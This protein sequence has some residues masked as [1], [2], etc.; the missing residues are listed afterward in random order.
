MHVGL[1]PTVQNEA[2]APITG[3]YPKRLRIKRHELLLP[4]ECQKLWVKGVRQ[5]DKVTL[6]QRRCTWTVHCHAEARGSVSSTR[7]VD[8]L[9]ALPCALHDCVAYHACVTLTSVAWSPFT[10]L[11]PD[12]SPPCQ[13]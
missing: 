10:L 2:L 3:T 9:G 11:R 7:K 13:A 8:P 6:I 12:H 5:T 1:G 4:P